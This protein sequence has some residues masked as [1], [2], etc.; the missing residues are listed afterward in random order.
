MLKNIFIK[1]SELLNRND[2]IQE[3][4]KSNSVDDISNAQIQSDVLKMTSYYNYVVSS[5]FSE[6][7]DL[8][9]NENLISDENNKIHYFNFSYN[10]L[11]ILLVTDHSHKP[12]CANIFTGYIL[13][14]APNKT[15]NVTYKYI[16]EEITEFSAELNIPKHLIKIVCYGIVSEFLACKNLYNESEFWKNKFMFE[17]F[18]HKTQKDRRIKSTFR[19]WN[20]KL[21]LFCFQTSK[22]NFQNQ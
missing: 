11:K 21:N 16:P 17:L 6:Y 5:I 14:N 15:F 7:I 4:K 9:F 8:T 1:C 18:K 2:I 19:I 20:N 10:P 22:T 12:V 13:T 3:L